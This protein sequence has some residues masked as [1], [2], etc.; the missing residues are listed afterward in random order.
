MEV[1]LFKE[2][3][4]YFIGEKVHKI[5]YEFEKGLERIFPKKGPKYRSP[6]RI[7]EPLSFESWKED[8]KYELN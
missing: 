5:N 2:Y 4:N 7:I 3:L 8:R 6:V 1:N